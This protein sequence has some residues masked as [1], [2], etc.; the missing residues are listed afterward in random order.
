MS[1]L[2][3]VSPKTHIQGVPESQTFIGIL[4]GGEKVVGDLP[5]TVV[6]FI[7]L[8]CELQR[9]VKNRV[10]SSNPVE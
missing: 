7:L 6:L 3:N 5:H 8:E 1:A 2:L 9:S 10:K 4:R